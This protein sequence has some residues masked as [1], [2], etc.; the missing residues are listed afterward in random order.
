MR[1]T[2]GVA[3]FA[4]VL[5]TIDTD[6]DGI[7]SEREGRAYAE[8]VL[9]D[10]SLTV[11][12]RGLPLHLVSTR[13]PEIQH[14]REGLGEIHIEFTA[15]VPGAGGRRKLVFENRHQSATGAYLVN[16][17][18][19]RDPDIR[20]IAQNRNYQQSVYQLEYEQARAVRPVGGALVG[21]IALVLFARLAM[22]SRREPPQYARSTKEVY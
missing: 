10:L 13:I 4:T 18:V 16:C 6:Y 2:P 20:I 8:G 21:I 5:G 9:R 14:M 15:D 1:L 3:V 12:G 22:L 11:D 19:P 17:L 7:I